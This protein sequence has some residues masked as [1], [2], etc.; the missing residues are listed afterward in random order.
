MSDFLL[1]F[2]RNGKVVGA[3]SFRSRDASQAILFA[4][5]HSE[6]T[7]LWEDGAYHTTLL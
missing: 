3:E 2:T 1:R 4:Q 7:E 6:P 5:R